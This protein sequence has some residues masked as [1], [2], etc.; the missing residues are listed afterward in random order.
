MSVEAQLQA[1]FSTYHTHHDFSGVELVKTETDVLHAGAYGYASRPWRIANTL[2]TRFDTAS[3]TK[4]FTTVAI[5]QL[6]DRGT[7]SLQTGVI[8]LL[9]LTDTTISRQVTVY[10][11]LTHTS[12]I[13]DDADKE[14]GDAPE[15]PHLFTTHARERLRRIVLPR[16]GAAEAESSDPEQ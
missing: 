3:I 4:L 1:M 16:R 10:H 14:A 7:L 5:L 13:G 6:I 11:L 8:E 15:T 9:G 2:C 12:G